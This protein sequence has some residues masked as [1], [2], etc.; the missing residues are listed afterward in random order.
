MADMEGFWCALMRT[1][2][3]HFDGV[4]DNLLHCVWVWLIV[5]AN[6]GCD[7]FASDSVPLGVRTQLVSIPFVDGMLL[8]LM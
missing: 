3:R 8:I 6:L 1:V 7:K 2:K 5:W 4:R